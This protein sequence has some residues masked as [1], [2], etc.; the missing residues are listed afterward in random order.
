MPLSTIFFSYIV[1]VSSIGGGS[2][3]TQ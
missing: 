1:A 3:S 2:L